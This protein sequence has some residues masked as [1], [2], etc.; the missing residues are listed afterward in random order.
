MTDAVGVVVVLVV[1]CCRQPPIPEGSV[2]AL[3]SILLNECIWLSI[4]AE[5]KGDGEGREVSMSR[6]AGIRFAL[7]IFVSYF[8]FAIRT[9]WGEEKPRLA[10]SIYFYCGGISGLY[11]LIRVAV[12]VAVAPRSPLSASPSPLAVG[13]IC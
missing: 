2:F 4:P 11:L 5:G 10:R 7:T 3:L 12:A 1:V 6:F 9:W 8:Q 13:W